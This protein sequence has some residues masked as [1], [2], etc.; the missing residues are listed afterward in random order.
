MADEEADR[1]QSALGAGFGSLGP[2][3][4]DIPDVI[5]DRSAAV[6]WPTSPAA[7][8]GTDS[9]LTDVST[10]TGTARYA[11]V[12]DLREVVEGDASPDGQGTTAD[13][14]GNRGGTHIPAGHEIQR[15]HERR[16]CWTRQGKSAT[17]TMGCYGIGV[18]RVVAAAIEQNH[19]ERGIIWPEAMA[20]FPAG[21]RAAQHAEVRGREAAARRPSTD[22]SCKQ[23]GVEVLTGRSQ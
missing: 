21:H 14:A 16:G 4:L 10:G 5:V 18:S 2:V 19:D 11:R 6:P 7:P 9:H 12:E 20:P 17:M 22:E 8:I 3:G 15:G 23:A 13:Q 1:R